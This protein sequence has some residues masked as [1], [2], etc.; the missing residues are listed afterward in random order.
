MLQITWMEIG[1][2]I[3]GQQQQMSM[4]ILVS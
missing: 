2:I 3:E 1:F 4:K